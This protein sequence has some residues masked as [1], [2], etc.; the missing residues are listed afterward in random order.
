M[1]LSGEDVFSGDRRYWKENFFDSVIMSG[2]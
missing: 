2:R 1:L